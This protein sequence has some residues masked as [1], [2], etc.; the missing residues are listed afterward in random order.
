MALTSGADKIS[1]LA[2][3]D[4][5]PAGD[6]VGGTTHMVQLAREAGTIDIM[7]LDSAALR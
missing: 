1:L 7:V 6:D 5:K 4:G 3:W 2:L